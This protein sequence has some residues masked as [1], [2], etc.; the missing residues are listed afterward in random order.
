VAISYDSAWGGGAT[1]ATS[2]T[3]GFHTC[4]AGISTVIVGVA[5]Q[6]TGTLTSVTDTNGD[7]YILG[8]VV[9]LASGSFGQLAYC[10]NPTSSSKKITAT[11][12]VSGQV[13]LVAAAFKGL[14]QTSPY[15]KSHTG[16]GGPSGALD[17]G[18]TAQTSFPN[19]LLIGI[20]FLDTGSAT[21][22]TAGA[23]YTIASSTTS[24]TPLY[25]EYQIV[26]ASTSYNA[27]ATSSLTTKNWGALIATFADTPVVQTG[28]A[29]L[30]MHRR[31]VLYFI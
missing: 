22:W 19:E 2:I 10:V 9:T 31:N 18:L 26:A 17:S 3:S 21:T 16:I 29:V 1:N 13:S 23:G 7:S 5:W 25:L 30:M 15:D 24:N 28:S 6:A 8:P 11:A 27:P 14:D 4:G 12:N 20:G